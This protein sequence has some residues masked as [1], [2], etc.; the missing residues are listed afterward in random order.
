MAVN[1]K[2]KIEY[3]LKKL[4]SFKFYTMYDNA[5]F[6]YINNRPNNNCLLVFALPDERYA[7]TY[8]RS[9]EDTHLYISRT[10]DGGINYKRT[11]TTPSGRMALNEWKQGSLLIWP[12]FKALH[13]D[14]S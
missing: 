9:W 2:E 13:K 7:L 3:I 11:D 4:C 5:Y 10:D 8:G 12:L 1:K 14:L 6:Y